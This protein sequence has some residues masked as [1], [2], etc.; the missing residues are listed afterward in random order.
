MR[1]FTHSTFLTAPVPYRNYTLS[2]K[3]RTLEGVDIQ[4]L[5]AGK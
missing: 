1:S 2:R 3:A 5:K 4:P